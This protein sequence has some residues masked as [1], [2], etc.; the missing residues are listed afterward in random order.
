M[1]GDVR[2]G[3][4]LESTEFRIGAVCGIGDRG[5]T[6]AL[7]GE[8]WRAGVGDPDLDGSQ[9]CAL[10]AALRFATRCALVDA[11]SMACLLMDRRATCNA[12]RHW[13]EGLAFTPPRTGSRPSGRR[14]PRE[15]GRRKRSSWPRA[16]RPH[17]VPRRSHGRGAARAPAPAFHSRLEVAS[18]AAQ[19]SGGLPRASILAKT[20]YGSDLL[21]VDRRVRRSLTQA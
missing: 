8:T 3:C 20:E 19:S 1:L 16:R 11:A 10:R 13:M 9:P 18:N 15:D 21:P 2:R 17:R 5:L 6:R 12:F 7:L 14:S 4:F